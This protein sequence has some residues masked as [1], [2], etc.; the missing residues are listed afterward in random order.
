VWWCQALQGYTVSW[1]EGYEHAPGVMTILD[2]GPFDT[3]D[4]LRRL[5]RQELEDWLLRFPR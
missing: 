5:W 2:L 1:I 4:D 3:D